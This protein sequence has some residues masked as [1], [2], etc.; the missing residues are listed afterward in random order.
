MCRRLR[1]NEEF[2]YSLVEV[3][4]S[5]LLLSIAIIPMVAV[6]DAGLRAASTSGNYDKARAFANKKLEQTKSLP[7]TDVRD[8]FPRTGDPT[9]TSGSPATIDNST[10]SGVPEGFSYTV[11]KRYLTMNTSGGT[12]TLAPGGATDTGLIEVTVTVRWGSGNSFGTTGVV[13]KGTL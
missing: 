11:R 13:S 5:I 4:V 6:F 2:G 12:T 10:E 8:N 7:Y 1:L 3:M 9:P